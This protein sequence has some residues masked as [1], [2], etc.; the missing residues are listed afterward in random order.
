[1]SFNL[2]SGAKL[3]IIGRLRRKSI[4]KNE[5]DQ[6]LN[7]ATLIILKL[8]KNRPGLYFRISME[9]LS[10]NSAEDGPTDITN[11]PGS[12]TKLPDSIS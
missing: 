1:M 7:R 10:G 4:L 2:T 9:A 11:S 3:Q 12:T 8:F 5:G 6:N